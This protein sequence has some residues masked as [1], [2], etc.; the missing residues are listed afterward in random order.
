MRGN[1][2]VLQQGSVPPGQIGAP[3]LPLLTF[4]SNDYYHSADGSAWILDASLINTAENQVILVNGSVVI[5]ES[6]VVPGSGFTSPVGMTGGEQPQMAADGAWFVRGEN[7]D[8]TDWVVRNGT[9]VAK[10]DDP[11]GEPAGPQI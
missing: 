2:I 4:S 1:S 6:V 11:V 7:V 8:G 10:T 5:Q 3:P 9:V